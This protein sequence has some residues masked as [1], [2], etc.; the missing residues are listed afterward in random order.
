VHHRL[1]S[2]SV[3][4]GLV[5][6]L[7]SVT[8]NWHPQDMTANVSLSPTPGATATPLPTPTEV[9]PLPGTLLAGANGA[10][11]ARGSVFERGVILSSNANVAPGF[12]FTA[13]VSWRDHRF[14]DSHAYDLP[15]YVKRFHAY[16]LNVRRLA[17]RQ[18]SSV[19]YDGN[20][21]CASSSDTANA[22]LWQSPSF[23]FTAPKVVGSMMVH[24][25]A[26]WDVQGQWTHT[27]GKDTTSLTVDLFIDKTRGV[28]LRSIEEGTI[29]E[30]GRT[31]KITGQVDYFNYGQYVPVQWPNACTSHHRKQGSQS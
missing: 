6:A 24:G 12:S 18:R 23:S 5:V 10:T 21:T 1:T 25:R 2:S 16:V 30:Q 4:A 11:E 17:V 14:R 26:A 13:G 3:L 20:W 15:V 27:H 28:Y 8:M 9:V 22:P 31:S 7:A 29:S 19:S